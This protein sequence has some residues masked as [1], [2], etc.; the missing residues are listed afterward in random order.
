MSAP[1]STPPSVRIPVVRVRRA[2]ECLISAACEITLSLLISRHC[3]RAKL[4]FVYFGVS[5]TKILC[6][7]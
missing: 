5:R 4:D 1:A 7:S 6:F 3:G 2:L